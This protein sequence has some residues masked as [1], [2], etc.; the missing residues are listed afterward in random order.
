MEQSRVFGIINKIN[1]ILFLVL[2]AGG[3]FLIIFGIASSNRWQN[4]RAVEVV[5]NDTGEEQEKIELV[6]GNIASIPGYDTQYVQLRSRSSGGKFS[7]YSGGRKTR[8]VLFFTGSELNTHWLYQNHTFNINEFSILKQVHKKDKEKAL[9]IYIETIKSDSNGDNS[10]DE[11]DLITISLTDPYGKNHTEIDNNVQSVI[12]SN[13]VEDGGYLILLMQKNNKVILK[14]YSLS[15]F[16]LAS[17]KVIN[18][19]SKK[20]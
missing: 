9:A 3:C 18:E 7:S 1:S 15:T 8:N 12:D 14:K 5:Q 11:D 19:I 6:L 17:E 2:L 20:L 16:K 13:V 10:L 4:R